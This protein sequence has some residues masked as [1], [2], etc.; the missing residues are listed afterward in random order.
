[1]AVFLCL[2]STAGSD[3]LQQDQQLTFEPSSTSQNIIIPLVNDDVME[4]DETFTLSLAVAEGA[5]GVNIASPA[6]V[7]I[8]ITDDDGK[9]M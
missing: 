2:L 7:E 1:M 8:T 6:S 4:A 3:Y 9:C 5:Q